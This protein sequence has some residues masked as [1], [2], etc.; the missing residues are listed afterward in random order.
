[1]L[2]RVIGLA[3]AAAVASGAAAQDLPKAHFKVI[4][5]NSP[6][7]VSIYDELPFWRKTLPETSKGAVTAD[8]TPL[9]HEGAAKPEPHRVKLRAAAIISSMGPPSRRPRS[10]APL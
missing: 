6:T 5:L 9:K 7:P 4:G 3:V 2:H 1:M 10:V 8:A